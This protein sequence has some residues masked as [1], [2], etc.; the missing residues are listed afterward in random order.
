MAQ[1]GALSSF[2]Y[3]LY[4]WWN[5]Q[6]GPG[7]PCSEIVGQTK[8]A[9]TYGV[10]S[11]RMLMISGLGLALCAYCLGLRV[12]RKV[13]ASSQLEE[14]AMLQAPHALQMESA[15]DELELQPLKETIGGGLH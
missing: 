9:T 5:G 14:S 4:I 11:N 8:I 2:F 3:I 15:E 12:R 6:P 1:Y 7:D 10:N 13:L